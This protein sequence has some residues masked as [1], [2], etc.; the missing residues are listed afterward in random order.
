[1]AYFLK[2]Y[3]FNYL[4][5]AM[6]SQWARGRLIDLVLASRFLLFFYVR[7]VGFVKA[8]GEETFLC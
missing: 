3:V 2:E 1:M 7:I 8:G 5:L 6:G 4:G